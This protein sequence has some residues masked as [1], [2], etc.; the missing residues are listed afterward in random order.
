MELISNKI[1]DGKRIKITIPFDPADVYTITVEDTQKAIFS[2]RLD[3]EDYLTNIPFNPEIP[4]LA[5]GI[6]AKGNDL[7]C[8]GLLFVDLGDASV[9]KYTDDDLMIFSVELTSD[10]KIKLLVSL[11]KNFCHK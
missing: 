3:V 4:T 5:L 9:M 11:L 2:I 1:V 8:Q 7:Y 10:E 6:E